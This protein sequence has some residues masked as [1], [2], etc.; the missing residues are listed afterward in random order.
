[1]I[2]QKIFDSTVLDINTKC[3]TQLCEISY[4][5]TAIYLSKTT[6]GLVY[7]E[8]KS[9]VI[10]IAKKSCEEFN[11]YTT[12]IIVAVPHVNIVR[13]YEDDTPFNGDFLAKLRIEFYSAMMDDN[14]IKLKNPDAYDN[15]IRDIP[16]LNKFELESHMFKKFRLIKD[17][18]EQ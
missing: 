14:F 16:N 1:M 12:N 3:F 13:S 4:N 10:D 17:H 5:Y 8:F 18:H 11:K 15:L 7:D 2:E 9:Y 6:V